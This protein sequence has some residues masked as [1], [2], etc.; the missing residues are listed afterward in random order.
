M[1]FNSSCQIDCYSG[2]QSVVGAFQN[3][4]IVDCGHNR[5]YIRKLVKVDLWGPT[6][7]E[8]SGS[9]P[10]SEKEQLEQ[11]RV[12]FGLHGLTGT[13]IT[14]SNPL[15]FSFKQEKKSLSGPKKFF[16][17]SDSANF[18]VFFTFFGLPIN[19]S[20]IFVAGLLTI[21]LRGSLIFMAC[22]FYGLALLFPKKSV[23]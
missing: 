17:G 6:G 23:D 9:P 18:M 8:N 4:E 3:V 19:G 5:F 13:R 7:L 21:N 10:H 20:Y 14:Q 12:G 22:R 16:Q 11:G 1:F 2:V 15:V